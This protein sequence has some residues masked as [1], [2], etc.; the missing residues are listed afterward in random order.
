[1]S[2]ITLEDIRVNPSKEAID[3]LRKA[4]VIYDRELAK[5]SAKKLIS[6]KVNP[7]KVI[8]V[9]IEAI[10]LIGDAYEEGKLFLPELVGASDAMSAAMPIAE[11]ELKKTGTKGES[12]GSVV[13]GTV[14]GDIHSIGK[15]MVGTMLT[16][17]GFT[18]HDI[19]T[20]A[21]AEKFIEAVKTY[22]PNILAMSALLTTTA[23]EQKKVMSV[24]EKE[25]LREKVKV[26]VGGGAVTREFAK[27]IGA[28]GYDST[29]PGAAKL[30][31]RLIG[32]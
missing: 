6:D 14:F 1:M 30:A 26:M 5:D 11:E 23:S 18:V 3:Q 32:K 29:A 17:E 16:A 21:K 24:L 7:L 31:K 9:M 25:G 10:K 20:N 28:D 13:L 22:N 12:L 8:K 15:T 2:K 19:G 27:S 4:I